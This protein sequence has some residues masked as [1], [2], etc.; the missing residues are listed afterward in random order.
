MRK[1]FALSGMFLAA[2]LGIAACGPNHGAKPHATYTVNSAEK[3]AV[4]AK[5]TKCEAGANFV[6]KP[7]RVAFAKCLSPNDPMGAQTCVENDVTKDKPYNAA[8]RQAFLND[9]GSCIK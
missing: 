1:T 5:V 8:G 2:A 7:G 9:L 6:T 3:Q 4:Q